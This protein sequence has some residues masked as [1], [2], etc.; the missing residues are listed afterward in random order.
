MVDQECGE[1]LCPIKY[2]RHVDLDTT[3]NGVE[4][5]GATEV[6]C[7]IS[8]VHYPLRIIQTFSQISAL[9]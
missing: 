9:N 1:F 4:L 8:L 2:T 6:H 7:G 3:V 5:S